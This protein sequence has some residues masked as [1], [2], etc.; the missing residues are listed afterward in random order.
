MGR[1]EIE[2]DLDAFVER[3][4]AARGADDAASLTPFLPP[5]DHV[6]RRPVLIELARVELEQNWSGGRPL[7]LEQVCRR[8]VELAGDCEALGVLAFEEY[9]LRLQAGERPPPD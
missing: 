4:E 3:Y 2:P 9:R 1:L 6:L 8:H 5:L 7:S